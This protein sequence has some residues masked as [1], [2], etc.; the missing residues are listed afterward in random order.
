MPIVSDADGTREILN[1]YPANATEEQ[2]VWLG[3]NS[4]RTVLVW[5]NRLEIF[6]YALLANAT[7]STADDPRTWYHNA[8]SRAL[9]LPEKGTYPNYDFTVD[10]SASAQQ[11]A[12]LW[13]EPYWTAPTVTMFVDGGSA[14]AWIALV[15]GLVIGLLGVV[16]AKLT[17]SFLAKE[18]VL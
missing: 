5:P 15:S 8:I 6:V 7:G 10:R 18:H 13:A 14:I 9:V 4:T 11:Q 3:S 1:F 17:L 2:K 16:G 12:T